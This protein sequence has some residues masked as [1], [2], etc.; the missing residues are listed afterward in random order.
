VGL[1]ERERAILDFER[2][3]WQLEGP[4]EANIRVTFDLSPSRYRELLNG[5]A[6][7]GAAAAYDPLVIHR[8]RRQRA[9]RRRAR[10][11]GRTAGP[12][13]R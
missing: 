8:L 3:W 10:F 6:E 13:V 12:N 1:S 9:E 5:L 2:S 7:S 11:E 4:K